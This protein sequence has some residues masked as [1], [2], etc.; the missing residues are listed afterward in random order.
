MKRTKLQLPF[1]ITVGVTSLACGSTVTSQNEGDDG[2][3]GSTTSGVGG[4]VSVGG[5]TSNGV[6][7][8]TT[9]PPPPECPPETPGP[10]A[11]CD[12]S[13]DILCSY[14]VSCQSG[15]VEMAFVCE[16][17][18]FD[19][20]PDSTCDNQADSCAGTEF[21]CS[22]DTWWM[23][24]ATNPPSPCPD[25]IPVAGSPCSSQEMGGVWP[26]CGYACD[27]M[28]VSSGWTLATCDDVGNFEG[29]W[30]LDGACD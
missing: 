9:N 27:G 18:Q 25:A 11:Q 24:T 30:L 12:I 10:Y 1:L 22:G 28:D 20:A 5:S 3:G 14:E 4:S 13:P 21:H 26:T 7:G 19:F 29:Q 15:P 23:P 17:G 16:N 8:G 2:G 6:G